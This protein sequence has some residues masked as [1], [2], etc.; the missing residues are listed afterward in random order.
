MAQAVTHAIAEGA[1]AA[2]AEV[3]VKR[4]PET[5]PEDVAIAARLALARMLAVGRRDRV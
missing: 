1:R 5:V 2:G 4:V 3:D